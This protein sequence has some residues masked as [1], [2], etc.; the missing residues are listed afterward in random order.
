M[1]QIRMSGAEQ[2]RKVLR[3]LPK[4]IQEKVTRAAVGEIAEETRN[5]VIRRTP[6]DTGEL[7]GNIVASRGRVR[8][9]QA[10]AS[11]SVRSD[12]FYWRF[13]ELGT[14]KLAKRPF[15]RPAFD[16]LAA[17]IEAV[18]T[19]YLPSRV[20]RELKRLGRQFARGGAR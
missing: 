2:A 12:S 16:V 7:I 8:R 13:L 5:E 6:V 11:V 20:N 9:G 17:S 18:I 10:K 15:I 4:E 3:L 14:V 19:R 1:I